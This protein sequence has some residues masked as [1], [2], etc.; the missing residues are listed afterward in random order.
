VKTPKK[1]VKVP[2]TLGA[3]NLGAPVAP[4][5]LVEKKAPRINNLGGYAHA[6]KRKK[7]H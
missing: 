4:S 1:T 5:K 7:G 3:P 6:A 2:P